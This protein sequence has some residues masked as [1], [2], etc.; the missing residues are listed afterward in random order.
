MCGPARVSVKSVT[1]ECARLSTS[2][3]VE[4]SVYARVCVCV[5]EREAGI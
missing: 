4:E 5:S 3:D 1:G 2:V